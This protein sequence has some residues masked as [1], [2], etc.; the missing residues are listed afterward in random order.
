MSGRAMRQHMAL[1]G[2]PAQKVVRKRQTGDYVA[3]FFVPDMTQPVLA[4]E[5][6]AQ[7]IR[8]RL[9]DSRVISTHNT[10]ADWR[11]GAP[12]IQATVIFTMPDEAAG[13]TAL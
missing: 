7:Q 13:V 6:W 8:S 3:D 1:L 10:V 12:V 2:I 5:E 9:P 11:P 4:A